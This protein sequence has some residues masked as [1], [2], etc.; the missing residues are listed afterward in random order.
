MYSS[1][2]RGQRPVLAV[3]L[4]AAAAVFWWKS[5]FGGRDLRDAA[6]VALAEA[7]E[8]SAL[9][10]YVVEGIYPPGISYLEK[11]YGLRVNREDYYVLYEV[12]A[13]NIPPEVRVL[14]RK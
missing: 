14:N 3:M 8:R 6:A 1:K 12:F 10:C 13:S 4:L 2:R 7:V 11:H 5:A 9:Q